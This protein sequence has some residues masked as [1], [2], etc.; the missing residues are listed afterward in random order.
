M[1]LVESAR[2][3][4]DV[5]FKHRGRSRKGLDCAGLVWCAYEQLGI[6]HPDLERY[7]REP[8]QNGMMRVVLEALGRPAQLPIQEGDVLVLRFDKEPHHM[9][10]VGADRH[11]GLSM[12]HADGSPGVRRVVEHGLDKRW[13]DR[14]YAAF[15]GAV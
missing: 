10:I 8:H 13:R 14:V 3:F 4:L 12:I 2:S 5:P 6:K 15:R 7:G 1:T 9:A 11:Y